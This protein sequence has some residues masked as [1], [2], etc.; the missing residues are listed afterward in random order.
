MALE[1]AQ[2]RLDTADG[3]TLTTVATDESGT[4]EIDKVPAGRYTVTA[5]RA[6]YLSLAF[7]QRR[8][9]EAGRILEIADK[10]MLEEIDIA[11]PKGGII[12]A[13]VVDEF[14]DSVARARVLVERFRYSDGERRLMPIA[15]TSS[16]FVATTD[17]RGEVRVFGLP[18]GDYYVNA[19]AGNIGLAGS[20]S[21]TSSVA[22]ATGGRSYVTTYFPGSASA[23]DAERVSV[24]I[25]REVH[26][27]IPLQVA[28]LARVTGRVVTSAGETSNGSVVLGYVRTGGA[29]YTTSAAEPN[30]RFAFSALPPGEYFI[31]V[32]PR[33][34]SPTD[35]EYARVPVTVTGQDVDLLITTG[36]PGSFQGRF[37][38]DGQA[39]ASRPPGLQPT[40]VSVRRVPPMP[41]SGNVTWKNDG[42]F[43]M[44]GQFGERLIRLQAPSDGWYLKAVMLG[45]R[46]VT[47]TPINFDNGNTLTGLEVVVTQKQTEVKGSA[48]DRQGT[49]VLEY[50]AVVF[51]EDRQRW[52]AHSRH[53]TAG[54]PDQRGQFKVAGLP[55]G[56]YLASAVEFL[57]TGQEHDPELLNRL[58]TNAERV[59]LG[60]G[61]SKSVT[62]RITQLP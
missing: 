58:A 47:D 24:Q 30:G 44:T 16:R 10:P 1:H 50:V 52:T 37:V 11:L 19:M 33:A 62:L 23:A 49:G 53:T 39:P 56:S 32:S 36:R 27:T 48:V 2:V 4:Y 18:P 31:Q 43:E 20:L 22:G 59:V 17:D 6:A 12:V 14:G 21:G 45:G 29:G 3:R 57:E 38:F 8:P 9:F 54:R 25:G 26:L 40:A 7:G 51:S 60:E 28:R 13:R 5:S 35:T 42:T 61:E 34:P 55:P 15:T 41:A 46:D